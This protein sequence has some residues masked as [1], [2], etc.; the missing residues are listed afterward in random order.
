MNKKKDFISVII[1]NFNKERYLSNS[2]NSVLD[3]NYKNFE[4]ILFD[5]CSTDS[6]IDIIKKFKKIRLIKNNKKRFTSGPLNQIYGILKAFSISKGNL[7]CL[8]DSDDKFEKKKLNEV[9]N[10]FKTKTQALNLNYD[11]NITKYINKWISKQYSL[12]S[13]D[14]SV[15]TNYFRSD[16]FNFH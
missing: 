3:Q 11:K 16:N 13:D 8:L 2:L 9:N 7:V 5:D 10:F 6:S 4:I 15:D 1:T 14:I 12:D